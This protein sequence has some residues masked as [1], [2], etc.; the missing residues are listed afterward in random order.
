VNAIEIQGLSFRYPDGT[1]ALN[2]LSLTVEAGERVAILG[3]NGAGKSTLLL[4]FNG[5]QTASNGC[6]RVFGEVVSRA[7]LRRVRQRVGFVFQNPDD[8]LFCPTLYE[9]VAFGPR[10]LGLAEAEVARRVEDALGAVGL[11]GLGGKSAYHLSVGQKKRAALATV[12][13]MDAEVLVLDEPTAGLDPRGRRELLG[14]LRGFGGTQVIATHDLPFVREL[15]G[16]AVVMAEGRVVA[17]GEPGVLLGDGRLL[18]EYGL[19]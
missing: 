10:N 1:I 3:P 7:S 2:D 14:L 18:E 11:D 15:C 17:E 16:R 6:V 4:H 19:A 5:I 9:D 8:Q 12:L 13:A